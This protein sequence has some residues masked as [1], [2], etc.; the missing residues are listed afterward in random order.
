MKTL[1]EQANSTSALK[2]DLNSVKFSHYMLN[3]AYN[4]I[5]AGKYCDKYGSY[6]LNPECDGSNVVGEKW[7]DQRSLTCSQIYDD[8]F[9]YCE[10]F[11]IYDIYE[12]LN[13][14]SC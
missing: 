3:A 9:D 6:I 10:R 13:M 14:M 11:N 12:L 7:K 8:N 4:D 1:I 5:S 2:L